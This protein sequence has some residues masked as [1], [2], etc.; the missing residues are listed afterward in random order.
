MSCDSN[1]C[2]WKRVFN[3]F[4]YPTQQY[5]PM[6]L[7][8]SPF[9]F[10]RLPARRSYTH[11]QHTNSHHLLNVKKVGQTSVDLLRRSE[12]I[13]GYCT[14]NFFTVIWNLLL[15]VSRI[16]PVTSPD[17]EP[18]IKDYTFDKAKV[19]LK[20]RDTQIKIGWHTNKIMVNLKQ[21][22]IKN[23]S[24]KPEVEHETVAVANKKLTIMLKCHRVL[25][26]WWQ[27]CNLKSQR[28]VLLRPA[29]A[30]AQI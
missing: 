19:L 3:N 16:K 9:H 22:M 23:D 26:D 17:P 8:V 4:Y 5:A 2:L 21:S 18:S 6:C 20:R 25:R 14:I 28:F 10:Q 24:S 29:A 7:H 1:F 11:L 30:R 13:C 15:M 27:C 12:R